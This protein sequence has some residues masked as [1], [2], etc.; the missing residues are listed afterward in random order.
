MHF[1]TRS[2]RW[3][4]SIVAA[5]AVAVATVAPSAQGPGDRGAQGGGGVGRGGLGQFPP[6]DGQTEAAGAGLIGGRVV[7]LD[8]G[9]PLR[10]AQVRLTAPELRV[11]RATAT[12]N[13][14]QF[15]FRD[16]P[17][18]RYTLSAGKTGYLTLDYGQR[19][20]LEPGTP[21]ELDEGQQI[22]RADFT[23]PRGSV[24]T[25]TI[26]DEFGE[27][28]PDVTVQA[29]RFEYVGG[30]PQ[31]RPA[32]R[33]AQTNDIGQ[34]RIFGLP[35]AGYY[36]TATM[37][38]LRGDR[39]RAAA[40][41][42]IAGFAGRGVPDGLVGQIQAL[43]QAPPDDGTGYAPTYYPGTPD[44]AQAQRVTVG[45]TDEMSGISFSMLAVRLARISGMVLDSQ[46]VPLGR[47]AVTLQ[48]S[49][50]GPARSG[51]GGASAVRDGMF[52]IDEV[53]PGSYILQ[54]RTGGRGR[55]GRGGSGEFARVP[56]GVNGADIDQLIVATT[57][58]ATVSGVVTFDASGTEPSSGRLSINAISTDAE[59][60]GAQGGRV[61]DDGSFQ[62]RGLGGGYLFRVNN[63][64]SGW[65]L[66][67]VSLNGRDI[68]DTPYE[69]SGGSTVDGLKIELTDKVTQIDGSAVG[70]RGEPVGGYTAV[71]FAQD[72]ELWGSR[73]RH[74]R[75]ARPDQ[76]GRFE[77]VGL[78]PGRY[79]AVAVEYLQQGSE[80]DPYLLEELSSNASSFTL[81]A[82]E[83]Y[84][85]ELKF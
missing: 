5:A 39:L 61:E 27:P 84:Q 9:A 1:P 4:V 64:P 18:G 85:L 72:S 44:A 70:S 80:S 60:L 21:V 73:S 59:P 30:R 42:A 48:P 50:G 20:P 8:T 29:M 22:R 7:S 69:F 56:V 83:T 55:G 35:P 75:A 25:G 74:V 17:P 14:G 12:D 51:I 58:G 23:L 76:E 63:V 26:A 57:P 43:A 62:L 45:L 28:L 6:R 31:L 40:T 65:M 68:T 37:P 71:V 41:G 52:T 67:S 24:I 47:A 3:L 19:R 11:S 46:G 82:G 34:F 10:R 32:G 78:P 13:E 2:R 66:E 36:V 16:L 38:R 33:S 15:E 77:I 79:F 53:P 54:V 49:G 81:D